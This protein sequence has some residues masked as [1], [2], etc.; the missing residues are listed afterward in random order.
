M[1][2]KSDIFYEL[3]YRQ[4][5]YCCRESEESTAD[6]APV[7]VICTRLPLAPAEE[8]FLGKILQSVNIDAKSV[9]KIGIEEFDA[10]TYGNK[11]Y[12]LFF[13]KPEKLPKEL[14]VFGSYT[15]APAY[16]EAQ[17]IIADDLANLAV[18]ISGKRKLWELLKQTFLK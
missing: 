3:L 1:N 5:I 18:D 17:V 6:R 2:F 7:A 12:L 8:E 11:K 4:P 15:Q 16:R 14:A 9:K 10:D 13:V